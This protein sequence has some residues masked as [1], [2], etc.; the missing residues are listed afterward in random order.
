MVTAAPLS[1][2]SAFFVSSCVCF[3]SILL[4]VVPEVRLMYLLGPIR[5][6]L[7]LRVPFDSKGSSSTVPGSSS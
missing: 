3:F 5:R 2:S 4:F 7:V 6:K 1:S